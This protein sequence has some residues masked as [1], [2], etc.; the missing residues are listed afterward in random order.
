VDCGE[1]EGV[2]ILLTGI[3]A[4]ANALAKNSA[5]S[6][7]VDLEAKQHPALFSRLSS[8]IARLP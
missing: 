3:L 5:L 4:S 7:A 6:K 1:G 2:W 8:R